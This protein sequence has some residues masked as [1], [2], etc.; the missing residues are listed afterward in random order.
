M[1]PFKPSSEHNYIAVNSAFILKNSHKR[2]RTKS[3]TDSFIKERLSEIGL[4]PC[5]FPA[6]F[7]HDCAASTFKKEANRQ[8]GTLRKEF[9]NLAKVAF[10]SFEI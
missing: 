5:S 6:Y 4:H 1:I 8:T 9:N 3:E 10:Y 2:N 7:D